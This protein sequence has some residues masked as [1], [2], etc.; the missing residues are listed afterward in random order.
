MK[1]VTF[2]MP[3]LVVAGFLLIPLG[4]GESAPIEAGDGSGSARAE[5][6][7]RVGGMQ[8]TASGAT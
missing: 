5:I 6:T 8:K 4:C 1:N 2:A 3:A 7:F